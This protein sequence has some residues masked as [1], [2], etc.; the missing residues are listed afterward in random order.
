MKPKKKFAFLKCFSTNDIARFPNGWIAES[1]VRKHVLRC[2]SSDNDDDLIGKIILIKPNI[3]GQETLKN[4][5]WK[6]DTYH[7]SLKNK[8]VRTMD[9]EIFLVGKV[10]KE[11]IIKKEKNRAKWNQ[12]LGKIF[13]TVLMCDSS[14]I[15]ANEF[16]EKQC[17]DMLIQN[18]KLDVRLKL[19]SS[20]DCMTEK[21]ISKKIQ[22]FEEDTTDDDS[23][24]GNNVPVNI[25]RQLTSGTRKTTPK[26]KPQRK[27]QTIVKT[28]N[29]EKK[30]RDFMIGQRV[31]FDFYSEDFQ[32]YVK[33]WNKKIVIDHK[34]YFLEDG[35]HMFGIIE[36]KVKKQKNQDHA[37]Y[38]I[39]WE[40]VT[41]GLKSI[42]ISMQE[43]FTATHLSKQLERD[44]TFGK[45]HDN[46]AKQNG[47]KKDFNSSIH[48][49][50]IHDVDGNPIESEDELSDD[51]C[52]KRLY[53]GNCT[54][55]TSK[56]S[57]EE[58]SFE[59][60]GL[61]WKKDYELNTAQGIRPPRGTCLEKEYKNSFRTEIESFLTFLPITYWMWHL[62][63]TN[64]Y[65][66]NHRKESPSGKNPNVHK[67]KDIHISEL[68][69]F[70]AILMQIAT[71]PLCG[72]SYYYCWTEESK[73]WYTACK[74]MSRKRFDE[75]RFGLHWCEN[76]SRDHFRD[77]Q[78]GKLD[79]LYK[80]RPLLTVVQQ[81]LGRFINPCTNLSLDETCIAIRSKFAK[82]VT[83][84]NPNKPKGK[85][86]LK[87]YTVCENDHWC[88]LVI[89][90]CHRNQ[91]E[92]TGTSTFNNPESQLNETDGVDIWAKELL[93]DGEDDTSQFSNQVAVVGYKPSFTQNQNA[94]KKINYESDAFSKDNEIHDET[95]KDPN[96]GKTEMTDDELVEEMQKTIRTVT[97]MCRK[98]KNSGRIINMDNLYSSPEVFIALKNY[99][100]YARG[101]VRLNRKY[102][103]KFIK[104]LKKDMATLDRGS[105]QFA[106][107]IKHNMS[108]HCWHDSN[109]VHMLSSCDSTI[110]DVVERQ[111]GKNK[112]TISCP[113]AVKE[114]NENMQAV[115]QF[116]HL[117]SL[118][119]LAE[120]HT[121][122][123]Y[124]K[125][126]AMVL[127]DFVLV[128]AYLHMKI[129]Q[130]QELYP[131]P[132]K[133]LDRK[134]FMDNLIDSLLNLDWADMVRTQEAKQ[135]KGKGHTWITDYSDD[136]NED[137][138][139]EELF[140]D[141]IDYGIHQEAVNVKNNNL[142]RA[143]T[144]EKTFDDEIL[145]KTKK[146]KF[147]CKVCI[148]EGRGNNHRNSVFCSNH[149]LALCQKVNV[150]P[151]KQT[152]F[153]I[154][155]RKDK[156]VNTSSIQDWK[157]LSPG[158]DKWTCW[159][160]AHN[161]YIPN[162]LFNLK[163]A[164]NK[165]VRNQDKAITFNMMSKP[166]ILRKKAFSDT[167]YKRAV[168]TKSHKIL[169]RAGIETTLDKEPT[170]KRKKNETLDFDE[171]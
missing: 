121:F 40:Y 92:D 85:H 145:R 95:I 164:K 161:Y 72:T 149:G 122:T 86:H 46:D 80:V 115:D 64:I 52:G 20:V 42:Q 17:R 15:Q 10:V 12:E 18:I 35:K 166:F 26:K 16:S 43:A 27:K 37:D 84:Y 108:M 110:V 3:W 97:E 125:K 32:K 144:I 171:I 55:Y 150:H 141:E 69:T 71:K 112:V 53:E 81:N 21:D 25:K 65:L 74:K 143:V 133:K 107:N 170:I 152:V 56:E 44:E 67:I 158:Q 103:P 79:T 128:N 77:R 23:N 113:V 60:S 57:E 167:F 131:K 89:K 139:I 41:T 76:K 51:E 160:K 1:E 104:Y 48:K 33:D 94:A 47:H 101:T 102:L 9:T 34:Q 19:S 61:K 83:F 45:I 157:W 126:I 87:F 106:S 7:P 5:Y 4:E 154:G 36:S 117:I 99:G 165:N 136:D 109:P 30:K 70:Y 63:V 90:M 156:Y 96:P 124:Y 134:E 88:A 151:Q 49:F 105:Y 98:Y 82:Q 75:I 39:C 138:S 91:K 137:S 14:K 100:L 129:Y 29:K 162:D 68:M 31:A 6:A 50:I 73:V 153:K 38:E 147:Y 78:T 169:K 116:N 168:G 59:T 93:Q 118:F 66:E 132:K 120:N 58:R 2:I 155:T 159:E 130:E 135:S 127:M 140:E 24:D 62:K 146:S 11:T 54:Y 111:A 119:S 22:H 114:Y 123:K 142:C 28:K 13:E 148:F 8:D 163:D